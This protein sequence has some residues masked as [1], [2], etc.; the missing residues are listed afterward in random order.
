[1]AE[2][3]WNMGN[4]EKAR[5]IFEK[6]LPTFMKKG[7]KIFEIKIIPYLKDQIQET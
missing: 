6:I 4:K 2:T 5:A 1:M 7:A 3:L